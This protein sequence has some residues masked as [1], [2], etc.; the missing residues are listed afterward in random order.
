M[1]P[2]VNKHI[3]ASRNKVKRTDTAYYLF[4]KDNQVPYRV[5]VIHHRA[6]NA[7]MDDPMFGQS[8][9]DMDEISRQMVYIQT[10]VIAA[11]DYFIAGASLDISTEVAEVMYERIEKHL[12]AHTKAMRND[13]SYYIGDTFEVFEQLVEFATALWPRVKELR[14][15]TKKH[16]DGRD[17]FATMALARPNFVT[18]AV[19]SGS[20]K[21]NKQKEDDEKFEPCPLIEKLERMKVYYESS[22][23]WRR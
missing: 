21:S 6:H 19:Q 15:K 3:V 13:A 9:R 22:Q 5:S 10:P 8:D 14:N 23:S 11:V 2:G 16:S 18:M 20:I 7:A 12:D 1:Q 4:D 17:P